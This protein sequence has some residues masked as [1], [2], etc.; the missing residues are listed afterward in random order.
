MS[1]L[2][3]ATLYLVVAS[4]LT[5][6]VLEAATVPGLAPSSPPTASAKDA[7]PGLT[8]RATSFDGKWKGT[9]DCLHDPGMWPNDECAV[10]FTF[11]IQGANL[12]VEQTIRSKKGVDTTS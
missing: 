7:Q 6:S 3:F 2:K 12:S 4:I 8:L 11:V 1:P 9:V 5:P 10:R